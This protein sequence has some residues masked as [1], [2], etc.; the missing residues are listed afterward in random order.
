MFRTD[1]IKVED[2]EIQFGDF[3]VLRKHK[4]QTALKEI[5]IVYKAND[6]GENIRVHCMAYNEI[7]DLIEALKQAKEQF[8]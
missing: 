6:I 3:S 2:D 1:M 8:K 5:D 4:N 7:D